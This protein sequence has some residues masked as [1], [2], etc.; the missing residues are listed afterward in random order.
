MSNIF[1]FGTA[2]YELRIANLYTAAIDFSSLLV[3]TAKKINR[4]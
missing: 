2:Y 4:F 3:L 1:L